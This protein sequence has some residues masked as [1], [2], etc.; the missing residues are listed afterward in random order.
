MALVDKDELLKHQQGLGSPDY[1]LHHY[2]EEGGWLKLANDPDRDSK[3]SHVAVYHFWATTEEKRSELLATLSKWAEQTKT[4]QGSNVPVQ[5]AL[6]L[7][8]CRDRKLATLWLRYVHHKNND[9]PSNSSYYSVKDIDTFKQL[10]SSGT[11]AD[12]LRQVKPLCD[13]MEVHQ[14]K[15]FNG[16]L[17]L[18]G[19]LS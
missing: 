1:D 18:Q 12:L 16:H 13:K 14:S 6:V 4:S 5:S 7:R 3:T 9:C 17:N 19:R 8:E 11:L 10:Q 15:S 2:D